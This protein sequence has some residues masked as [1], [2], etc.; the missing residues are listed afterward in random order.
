MYP[1]L[2]W[3]RVEKAYRALV[4]AE[5]E[6]AG[7]ALAAVEQSYAAGTSD[8]FVLPTAIGNYEGM[9]DGDGLFMANFRADRAREI[10]ATLLDPVF[11]VFR[12]EEHTSE[13]QSLM[14]ISYAVFCLKKKTH[15]NSYT[16]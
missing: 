8:E 5:G 2:R 7:D 11:D 13:L 1:E 9:Q 4:Q 16:P 3:P 15:T 12:S 6:N 10:L 14:R